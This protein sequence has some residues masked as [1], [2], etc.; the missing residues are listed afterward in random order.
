MVLPDHSIKINNVKSESNEAITCGDN[1]ITCGDNF[2]IESE[3]VLW[4]FILIIT[5]DEY[6]EMNDT[7]VVQQWF[8]Y[9]DI[10]KVKPH[11]SEQ[12]Y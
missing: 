7:I 6:E 11:T 2:E 10:L 9:H 4:H 12:S 8:S 5:L 1:S 3:S